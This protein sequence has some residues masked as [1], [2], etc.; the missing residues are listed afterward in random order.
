MPEDEALVALILADLARLD[1]AES[2]AAAAIQHALP[3]DAT[4]LYRSRIALGRVRDAQGRTAEAEALY[5]EAAE[6]I[7]ITEYRVLNVE[8]MAPL[9]L[10]LLRS[11][12]E[13]EGARWLDR[14]LESARLWGPESPGAVRLEQAAR[15][16][17]EGRGGP[18]SYISPS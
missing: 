9:A 6:I 5:R 3:D 2:L 16:A 10:L 11:G 1:E 17:R 7:E 14:A 8:A 4:A 18:G 12:R 15:D 13:E